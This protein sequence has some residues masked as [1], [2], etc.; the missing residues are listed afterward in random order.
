MLEEQK[1]IQK[2]LEKK[3]EALHKQEDGQQKNRSLISL[4]KSV[5]KRLSIKNHAITNLKKI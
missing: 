5:R 3:I 2:S 4:E 1:A